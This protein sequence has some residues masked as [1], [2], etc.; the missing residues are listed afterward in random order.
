M[1]APTAKRRNSTSAAHP[2]PPQARVRVIH[3]SFEMRIK[4]TQPNRR[5]QGS[6]SR[7]TRRQPKRSAYGTARRQHTAHSAPLD[8]PTAACTTPLDVF[9]RSLQH[10]STSAHLQRFATRRLPGRN[11]R[12]S[13]SGP[14]RPW[15]K[16]KY[17]FNALIPGLGATDL[18]RRIC[19]Q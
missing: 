2:A 11:G 13:T 18:R 14:K 17:R 15:D 16:H 3:F 6:A 19:V 5:N 12:R 7:A 4:R 8:A 1:P 10:R 9:T